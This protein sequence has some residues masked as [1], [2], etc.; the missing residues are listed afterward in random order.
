MQLVVIPLIQKLYLVA[1]RIEVPE[2]RVVPI[3]ISDSGKI[4]KAK[5]FEKSHDYFFIHSIFWEETRIVKGI[6]IYHFNE[7]LNGF[8][9]N[10]LRL[11]QEH[12]IWNTEYGDGVK[13]SAEL[14]SF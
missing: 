14:V 12:L 4:L 6:F 11:G 9:T 3:S 2:N 1:D 8:V 5:L 10:K 13:R 7:I